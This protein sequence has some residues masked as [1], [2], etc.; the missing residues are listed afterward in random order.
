MEYGFFSGNS[1]FIAARMAPKEARMAPKKA[2]FP[3]DLGPGCQRMFPQEA[4]MVPKEAR[5]DPF[6]DGSLQM[7]YGLFSGISLFIAA[8]MAP[9]AARFQFDL[10]PGCQR[11]AP[12]MVE[13]S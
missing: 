11:M 5:R 7:E 9:K 3:F 10:G 6:V 12:K 2:R 4:R 8:R 1:L 13:L